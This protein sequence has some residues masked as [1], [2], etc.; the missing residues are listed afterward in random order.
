MLEQK[1]KN[2]KI[3][4]VTIIIFNNLKREK[5]QGLQKPKDK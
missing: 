1:K 3:V 2:A 4:L 5:E